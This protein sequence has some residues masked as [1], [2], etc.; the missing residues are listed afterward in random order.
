LAPSEEVEAVAG[1]LGVV[2]REGGDVFGGEG[3][4]LV[5][6]VDQ[7]PVAGHESA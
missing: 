3:L 1:G 6:Q 5:E 4:V 7:P 2:E